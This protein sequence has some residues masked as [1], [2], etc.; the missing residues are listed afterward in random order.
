[1]NA[2]GENVTVFLDIVGYVGDY[3]AV[4]HALN[5]LGHNSRAPVTFVLF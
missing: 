3:P 5:V 2:K 4:T 1:M